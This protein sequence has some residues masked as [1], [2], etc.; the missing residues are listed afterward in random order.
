MV[1]T[2]VGFSWEGITIALIASAF[3]EVAFSFI[4]LFIYFFSHVFGGMRLLFMHC[5][6][7]SNRKCWLFP[8]NSDFYTVHGPTNFIFYQFFH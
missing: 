6:I 5:C 1:S 7:N 2:M 4:Y 8:V 3:T